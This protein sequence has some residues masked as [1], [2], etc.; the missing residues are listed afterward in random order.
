MGRVLD[1]IHDD[2][3]RSGCSDTWKTVTSCARAAA[4]SYPAPSHP[5]T[6]DA[7]SPEGSAHSMFLVAPA[8]STPERKTCSAA[9]QYTRR[10]NRRHKYPRFP[11]LLLNTAELSHPSLGDSSSS[12]RLGKTYRSSAGLTRPFRCPTYESSIHFPIHLSLLTYT[13]VFEWLRG[14]SLVAMAV[15]MGD[16]NA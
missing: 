14:C 7:T 12:S 4:H 8:P 10:S 1:L 15:T 3:A 16:E 2:P 11:S 6:P 5:E 9:R 13:Y